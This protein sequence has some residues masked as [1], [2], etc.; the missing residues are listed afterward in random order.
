MDLL[1]PLWR[2]NNT[3]PSVPIGDRNVSNIIRLQC[4]QIAMSMV[5][6]QHYCRVYII[7][8]QN[9]YFTR[10]HAVL[11][12]EARRGHGTIVTVLLMTSRMLADPPRPAS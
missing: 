5:K 8:E 7:F 2:I 9:Q 10:H 6:A 11:S 3:I 12:S 1:G 4:L